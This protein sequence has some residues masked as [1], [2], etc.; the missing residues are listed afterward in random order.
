MQWSEVI[1][2]PSLRDLP[3]KIELDEWGRIVM[4]PASNKHGF[5]QTA[6][7]RLLFGVPRG[8]VITECSI[9]TPKGVKVADVAWCSDEFLGRHGLVTPY[10]QAPEICVEIVSPSNQPG[11]MAEKRALYFEAGAGEVWMVSEQGE[12]VVYAPEGV[13]GGSQFGKLPDRVT[14]PGEWKTS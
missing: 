2:D 1:S 8:T 13:R 11:E 7:A 4:S 5:L 10:P 6:I 12:I 3:Y 14:L 9:D